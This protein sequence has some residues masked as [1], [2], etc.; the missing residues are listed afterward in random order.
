M[1]ELGNLLER[2][3]KGGHEKARAAV[4]FGHYVTDLMR[5]LRLFQS[6]EVI[7]EFMYFSRRV[8]ISGVRCIPNGST[9]T[10]LGP[11]KPSH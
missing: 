2:L 7:Y 3:K 9:R 5:S 10:F 11:L 4:L 1:Q 8:T 6:L